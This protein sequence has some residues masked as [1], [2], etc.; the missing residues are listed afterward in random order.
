[1]TVS[2]L[3]NEYDSRTMDD[4]DFHV[5]EMSDDTGYFIELTKVFNS[6]NEAKDYAKHLEVVWG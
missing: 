4:L 5:L 6:V 1:M 2:D 3:E